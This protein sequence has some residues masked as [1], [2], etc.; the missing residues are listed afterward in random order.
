MCAPETDHLN[1]LEKLKRY[2]EISRLRAQAR[3]APSPSTLGALTERLVAHGQLEAALAAAEHALDLFPD[4][5]RLHQIRVFAKKKTLAGHIRSLRIDLE[6]RPS[7]FVYTS[8]AELSRELGDE[9]EALEIAGQCAAM[10]P[11]ND[12]PFLVQGEIRLERFLR[13][14]VARDAVEA[15]LALQ[16]V[17]RINPQHLKAH[18]LLAELYHLVGALP[19]CRRHLREVLEQSPSARD[20]HAFLRQLGSATEE[21]GPDDV[22]EEMLIS[23]AGRVEES[24]VFAG[25]PEAFPQ[26]I[27]H[28][29]TV[30]RRSSMRVDAG[31]LAAAMEHFA[32]TPGVRNAMLLDSE[33]QVVTQHGS[34]AGLGAEAFAE[35]ARGIRTTSDETSRRM[36]TG[37]LVRAE[38][39]G[40]DVSLT[41]VRLRQYTIAALYSD[42]LRTDRV[43]EMLQDLSARCLTAPPEVLHA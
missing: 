30:R 29:S 1:L 18:V 39:E 7:P 32:R 16:R 3:Q 2:R 37:V 41:V 43:W 14:Q 11:Q 4:S 33:G 19:A 38:I 17:V 42:P 34:A 8:L 36:D 15:E 5:E 31:G 40:P 10:F 27:A 21:V 6:R 24:G 35:L 9:D 13:D 22:T 25:P 28:T 20:V 23:L 12:Q 26:M